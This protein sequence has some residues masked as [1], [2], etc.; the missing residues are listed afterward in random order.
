MLVSVSA[1]GIL[2]GGLYVL[3]AILAAM[4]A[5]LVDVSVRDLD[6]AAAEIPTVLFPAKDA[7][8]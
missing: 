4:L 5:A 7:E 3:L 2:L 1:T 6:P 8:T